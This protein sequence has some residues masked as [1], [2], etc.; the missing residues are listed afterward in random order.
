MGQILL[1]QSFVSTMHLQLLLLMTG[2]SCVWICGGGCGIC[3]RMGMAVLIFWAS[4]LPVA[5]T[6]TLFLRDFSVK[7]LVVLPATM[8][9]VVTVT[10]PLPCRPAPPWTPPPSPVSP[11]L[12]LIWASWMRRSSSRAVRSPRLPPAAFISTPL[13]LWGEQL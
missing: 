9:A 3:G 8:G 1:R 13:S 6:L 5:L 2:G 7:G 4:R 10:L 12:E 11:T